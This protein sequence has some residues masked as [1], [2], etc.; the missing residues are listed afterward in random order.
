MIE[1]NVFDYFIL[2]KKSAYSD[3][4]KAK[5][6]IYLAYFKFDSGIL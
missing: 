6:E 5:T 2:F 1:C 4:Q 3:I